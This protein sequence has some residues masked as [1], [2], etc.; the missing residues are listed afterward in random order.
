M[1]INQFRGMHRLFNSSNDAITSRCGGSATQSSASAVQC[2]L[3]VE[4]PTWKTSC[5]SSRTNGYY[6][7]MAMCHDETPVQDLITGIQ[8]NGAGNG[9]QIARAFRAI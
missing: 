2:A 6:A 9:W 4:V 5:L 3:V 7:A 8:V 1:S